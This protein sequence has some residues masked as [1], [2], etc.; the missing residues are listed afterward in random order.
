MWLGPAPMRPYKAMY[1]EGHTVYGPEKKKQ[2][3]FEIAGLKPVPPVGTLYPL[4]LAG[5]YRFRQQTLG[6]SLPLRERDLLGPGPGCA[7]R[8]RGACG[9][10]NTQEMCPDWTILRFLW[11]AAALTRRSP[12][13]V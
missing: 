3:E 4:R 5:L 1:P 2:S 9:V 7:V 6:V 13:V 8:C 12:S 10:R 11:P